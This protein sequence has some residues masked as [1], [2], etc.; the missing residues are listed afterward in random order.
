MGGIAVSY[1]PY[2]A[3]VLDAGIT[4]PRCEEYRHELRLV[5][6]A[7]DHEN[8]ALRETLARER[9]AAM[10]VAVE[11]ARLKRELDKMLKVMG[12]P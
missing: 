1:F 2:Q 10:L 4:C 11:N 5:R 6:Q 7:L 12:Q 9:H 8:D 3:N